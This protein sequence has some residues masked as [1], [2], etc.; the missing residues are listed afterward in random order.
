MNAFTAGDDTARQIAMG[1]VAQVG[2]GVE[3]YLAVAVDQVLMGAHLVSFFTL[4][5]PRREGGVICSS[6]GGRPAVRPAIT[7]AQGISCRRRSP[8]RRGSSTWFPDTRRCRSRRLRGQGRT[9]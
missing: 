9:A 3:G 4:D 1:E 6:K 7:A 5:R 8:G 2:G